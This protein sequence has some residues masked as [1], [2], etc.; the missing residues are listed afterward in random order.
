MKSLLDWYY[1]QPT[2]LLITAVLCW[3]ANTVFG[4]LAVDQISPIMVV[5][6]RWLF[7]SALLWPLFGHRVRADWP[8]I[9]PR[10]GMT[11]LMA[12]LGFTGF[13][14]LFY[15]AAYTTGALNVGILQGSMPIFV[16]AGSLLLFGTRVTPLQIFGSLLGLTGVIAVATEGRPLALLEL[17]IAIGDGL[18]LIACLLYSFYTLALKNR[19]AI[20]GLSF[21]TLMAP[22]AMITA[23]PLV[24]GETLIQGFQW[25][26]L[27]GWLVTLAIAVFPSCIAQIV[28]LRAV[29]LIGPGPAGGY[30]NLTPVFAAAM[31]VAFLG[32]SFYGFH[33]AGLSLVIGGIWLV[34]RR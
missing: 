19:P 27:Q 6:T 32:E 23:L 3:G 14:S 9:K 13:N 2:L 16:L 7:V 12:S 1:Q 22:I 34:Q 20:S 33:A 25:P 17:D 21:F 29:D 4:Q 5:F 11:I 31:G 8:L 30:M 28:F 26:S 10:L 24:I 15:A 18:M